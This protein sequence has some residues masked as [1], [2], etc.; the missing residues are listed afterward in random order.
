[1]EFVLVAV[2]VAVV[3]TLAVQ[4]A[5]VPV[6]LVI[7]PDAGVPSTGAV[8]VVPPGSARVPVALALIVALPEVEPLITT[9]PP[10]PPLVPRVML[11]VPVMVVAATVLGV[12]PP[13][14]PGDGSDDVEPPRD[15]DVPAMVIAEFTKSPLGMEVTTV[16][17]PVVVVL[18]R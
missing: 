5:Q 6:R 7:T 8:I 13:I 14:A 18:W 11:L 12:V 16:G 4:D 15:T 17:T 10:V 9:L 1:V 3:A 2:A